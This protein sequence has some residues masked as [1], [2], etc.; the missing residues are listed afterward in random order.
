M[1]LKEKLLD[2]HLAFE[3]QSEVNETME[4][5]RQAKRTSLK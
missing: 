3:E 2:S 4:K 1:E 5:A